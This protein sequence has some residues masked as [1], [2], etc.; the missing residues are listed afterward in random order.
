FRFRSIFQDIERV[1]V[2]YGF[3]VIRDH[4]WRLGQN[5]WGIIGEEFTAVV[6]S[7]FTSG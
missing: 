4:T 6:R 5:V 7:F 1:S 2:N 3:T